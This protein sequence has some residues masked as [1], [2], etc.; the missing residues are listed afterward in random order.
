LISPTRRLGLR[1]VFPMA[2]SSWERSP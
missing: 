2:Q 1:F